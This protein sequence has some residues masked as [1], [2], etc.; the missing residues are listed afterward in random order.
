MEKIISEFEKTGFWT[1]QAGIFPENITRIHLHL[2]FGFRVVGER[3]KI[4]KM[5]YIPE[6]GKW[7]DVLFLERR[8]NEPG[9]LPEQGKKTG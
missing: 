1:L 6:A 9:N 2:S 4:G 7:R 5:S 8:K 3:S